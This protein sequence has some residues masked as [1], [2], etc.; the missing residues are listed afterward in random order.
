M[1]G[2]NP[3]GKN[4]RFR[5]R[6][7]WKKRPNLRWQSPPLCSYLSSVL[8]VRKSRF[9]T[10]QITRERPVGKNEFLRRIRSRNFLQSFV[11]EKALALRFFIC[12]SPIHCITAFINRRTL[13]CETFAP[14]D[15]IRCA[16]TE[17]RTLIYN[18]STTTTAPV[19]CFYRAPCNYYCRQ[20]RAT[21]VYP[22]VINPN[23]FSSPNTRMCAYV[24]GHCPR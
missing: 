2:L 7:R 13:T 24:V 18:W 15:R 21:V 5:R 23:A 10:K 4:K 3:D 20:T 11:L 16:H 1:I 12:F 19:F 9:N 14:V 17:G 6:C 8:N 22:C